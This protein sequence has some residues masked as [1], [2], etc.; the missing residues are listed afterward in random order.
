MMLEYLDLNE[1]AFK[2]FTAS[3]LDGLVNLKV[4][5]HVIAV[6]GHR[7]CIVDLCFLFQLLHV[8]RPWD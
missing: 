6:N 5:V 2:R 4:F 8:V 1:N 3:W 7:V